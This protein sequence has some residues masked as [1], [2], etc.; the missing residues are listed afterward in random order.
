MVIMLKTAYL[1]G[2]RG[3]FEGLGELAQENL[4]IPLYKDVPTR[5]RGSRAFRFN[6]IEN[7]SIEIVLKFCIV[8]VLLCFKKLKP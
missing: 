8:M 7:N 3:V 2:L 4:L 1:L 6:L 5:S